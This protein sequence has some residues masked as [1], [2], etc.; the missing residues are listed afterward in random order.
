MA[1]QPEVQTEAIGWRGQR[2]VVTQIAKELEN[3][4][5]YIAGSVIAK[6]MTSLAGMGQPRDF[7]A[8]NAGLAFL[9]AVHDLTGVDAIYDLARDV[10]QEFGLERVS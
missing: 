9:N 4:K 10:E 2:A 3:R 1:T 6:A 8:T 7:L 5:A